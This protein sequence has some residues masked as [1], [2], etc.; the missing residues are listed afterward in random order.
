[1]E[2]LRFTLPVDQSGSMVRE[3]RR[4]SMDHT[5]SQHGGQFA[6]SIS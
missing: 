2:P 1:V 3:D 4:A 6:G 5:L